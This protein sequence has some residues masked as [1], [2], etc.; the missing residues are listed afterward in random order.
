MTIGE[1]IK[2]IR[3]SKGLTQIQLSE[4]SKIHVSTIRKYELGI[5]E[6]NKI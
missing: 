1:K 2:N 4:L 5:T 3:E 6:L